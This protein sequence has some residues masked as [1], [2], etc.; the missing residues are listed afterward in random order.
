MKRPCA[1]VCARGSAPSAP[2]G[3]NTSVGATS[4]FTEASARGGE[5]LRGPPPEPA[6]AVSAR[7]A[8]RTDRGVCSDEVK[9][10]T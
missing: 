3:A 10:S 6:H 4:L 2:G 1:T 8:T 9:G 7:A 5:E